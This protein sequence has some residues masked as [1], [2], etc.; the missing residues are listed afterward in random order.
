MLDAWIDY[1][2]DFLFG[3]ATLFAIINP[4]GLS[5]IF[6]RRTMA[7]S[8]ADQKRVARKIA[9]YAFF[10]LVVSLFGGALILG[11]FGISISALRIAGGIVVA[12][13]RVGDAERTAYTMRKTLRARQR[14]T[15]PSAPWRSFR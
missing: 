9:V 6:L 5:F 1:G 8:H 15:R 12:S 3:F 11:F 13:I 4:Y 2:R 14:V 7:L 10:V